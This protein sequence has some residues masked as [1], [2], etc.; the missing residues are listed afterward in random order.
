M[1]NLVARSVMKR[2]IGRNC[3]RYVSSPPATAAINIFRPFDETAKATGQFI[4]GGPHE[5]MMK[6]MMSTAAE[7]KAVEEKEKKE[8]TAVAEKKKEGGGEVVSS[9]WGVSRPKIKRED[10]TEWPWNCFMVK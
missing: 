8:D 1:N 6:R 3:S 10:G 7:R 9:Y 2:V 5:F 4:G